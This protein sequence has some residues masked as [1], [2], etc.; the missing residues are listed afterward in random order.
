MNFPQEYR[1]Y[2][3]NDFVFTL[4]GLLFA[5]LST[6]A[7]AVSRTRMSTS[8]NSR[9]SGEPHTSTVTLDINTLAGGKVLLFKKSLNPSFKVSIGGVVTTF[10]VANANAVGCQF[11]CKPR[12]QP[13]RPD[14]SGVCLNSRASV[15]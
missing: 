15:K 14:H 8:K 3:K 7:T 6:Q 10:F 12:S 4:F 5:L 2:K 9:T 11:L 1:S 13:L